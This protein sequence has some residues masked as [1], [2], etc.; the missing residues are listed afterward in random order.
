M[1]GESQ[2]TLPDEQLR[3]VKAAS[4]K[5][6]ECLDKLNGILIGQEDVIYNVLTSLVA[7]GNVNLVGAPGLGKSKLFENTGSV[8]GLSS[9]RIQF[10]ADLMPMDII[11]TEVEDFDENGKKTFRLIEGPVFTQ[12]LMADEINRAAPRTQS[13]MLQAMQDKKVTVGA[14]DHFLN[15]G[16]NVVATQNPIEQEGTYPL[17][18]AQMDRFLMQINIENTT[19]DNEKIF[20]KDVTSSSFDSYRELLEREANGEDILQR[21]KGDNAAQV[22]AVLGPTDLV[23]M[24]ALAKT[25]PIGEQF[26]DRAIH[27]GRAVRNDNDEAHDDVKQKVAWGAGPRAQIAFVQ[28]ARARA[29]IDG[30]G[31]P[32]VQD[33]AALAK[34]VLRH[35]M[36]L[37]HTARARGDSL[38]GVIEGAVKRTLNL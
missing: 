35:R 14:V 4:E 36:A 26:L 12:L 9:K 8:L 3:A 18:E 20:V 37:Q 15:Q 10:T 29:L 23:K 5:L 6:Q 25:L 28:A 38:E 34:P 16:F 7:G 32:N 19:A 1:A 27:L 30:R 21:I 17:P 22:A 24:R 13:A 31:V 2:P 11:G 33:L